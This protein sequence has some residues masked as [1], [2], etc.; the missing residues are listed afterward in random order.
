LRALQTD[1]NT[2]ASAEITQSPYELA[3]KTVAQKKNG[4]QTL[5]NGFRQQMND[6]KKEWGQ[7]RWRRGKWKRIKTTLGDPIRIKPSRPVVPGFH[8]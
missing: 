3:W 2:K 1:T 5:V 7:W 8:V 6:R 4:A